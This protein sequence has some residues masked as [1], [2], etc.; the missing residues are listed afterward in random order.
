MQVLQRAKG[1]RERDFYCTRHTFISLALT[2]GENIKAIAEQC[3][4]SAQMIEQHYG[5]Y[6]SSDFGSRMMAELEQETSKTEMETEI[7]ERDF[8][9]AENSG[10]IWRPRRDLNPCYRRE[11]P[12]SW[13]E[14]DDGDDT[15]EPCRIRTGDPLLK[16]Q[17]LYRLS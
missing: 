9:K 1:I 12:V 10:E 4:T 15:G 5:R 17:M 11:R 13:A 16:R 3:G 8:A 2:A 6:M 14:L 7:S